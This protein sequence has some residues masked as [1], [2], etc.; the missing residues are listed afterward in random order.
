M[1]CG[2]FPSGAFPLALTMADVADQYRTL[3]SDLAPDEGAPAV[4]DAPHEDLAAA[5][6]ELR[7]WC[8]DAG[9]HVYADDLV[10]G[11]GAAHLLGI[12]E[13]AMRNWRCCYGEK[14]PSVRRGRRVYYRLEDLAAALLG[15][16]I[17]DLKLSSAERR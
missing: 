14:I 4:H 17:S 12:T 13:G 6:A 8:A 15:N 11:K 7:R 3:E 1:T 2:R 10:C 16:V 5:V 9:V